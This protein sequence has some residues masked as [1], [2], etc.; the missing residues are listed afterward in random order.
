MF[1]YQLSSVT[2]SDGTRIPLQDG[3]ILVLVGSNS[4]GKTQALRDIK[5]C[6]AGKKQQAIVVKELEESRMDMP[7]GFVE[8][9]RCNFPITDRPDGEFVSTIGGGGKIDDFKKRWQTLHQQG[10]LQPFLCHLASTEQRLLAGN[11]TGSIDLINHAPANYIHAVQK[12]DKIA[13]FLNDEVKKAF[14]N[15]IFINWG[16]GNSVWFHVG[17]EPLRSINEDRVSTAYLN[18][19]KEIPLLD[20][21]GDGIRSY[22][23]VLLAAYC[24]S[25]PVL[26]IDEPEAFLHPPQARKMGLVLGR[27]V[28]EY[29]KDQDKGKIP[30]QLILATHSSDFLQ[31]LLDSN[32]ELTIC[33]IQRRDLINPVSLLSPDD[34]K[35]LWSKPLLKASSAFDAIFHAGVIVCEGDSDC[36]FYQSVLDVLEGSIGPLDIK[37]HHGGG[38]DQISTLI[39][40]YNSLSIPTVSITDFDI[41]KDKGKFLKLIESHKGD[42]HHFEKL[43]N[44]V[45]ANLAATPPI[46]NVSQIIKEL[47]EILRR[48]KSLSKIEPRDSSEIK[49]ILNDSKDWSEAKK[50]G[51]RKLRGGAIQAC[52]TFLSECKNIGLFIVPNGTLESWWPEGSARKDEWI[53]KSLECDFANPNTFTEAKKFMR[54]ICDRLI[55]M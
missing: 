37:F 1:K 50:Y 17:K 22:I 27:I 29:Q 34:V 38:K 9:L 12:D 28:S 53:L 45:S 42:V 8:W 11:R 44:P 51:K 4:S 14:S 54:E 26:L 6:I 23:G 31:G 24:G 16:G 19:L 36:R 52:E 25:H 2:F 32:A 18:K 39:R 33:R 35:E 15:E 55:N 21:E 3:A 10:H 49:S 47:E 7:D 48:I 40:A 5:S 13:N 43:Y 41:L 20:N 30:R 46:K